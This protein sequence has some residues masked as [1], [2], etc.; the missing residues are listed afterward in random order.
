MHILDLTP[1]ALTGAQPHGFGPSAGSVLNTSAC[2][3]PAN[4][5]PSPGDVPY[6]TAFPNPPVVGYGA[7]PGMSS[8]PTQPWHR[9]PWFNP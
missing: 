1:R 3:N 9:P 6:T 4:F 7:P 8:V 2:P 5:E